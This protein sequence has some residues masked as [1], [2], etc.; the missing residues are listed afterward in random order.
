MPT[1]TLACG[2]RAQQL[3]Q[4]INL[5]NRHSL[6][7]VP[8]S[9][10]L[11]FLTELAHEVLPVD[12]TPSLAEIAAQP[13][14]PHLG[15]PAPAPQHPSEPLRF[16]ILGSDAALSAVLTRLM[17]AD[18]LWAEIAF[19]P[20]S[21]SVA[22]VNWGLSSDPVEAADFAMSA[23]VCPAPTI[24][25]DK[26]LV[27]AGS[28][29]LTAEANAQYTGEIIVDDTTVLFHR[30]SAPEKRPLFG[31]YG[32]RLIPMVDAPGIVAAK[33]IT[34][35]EGAAGRR[36]V[37]LEKLYT[38]WHT[39]GLRWLTRGAHQPAA[40]VEPEHVFQ[41]RAVQTGGEKIIVT[42]DG[43]AA[44]RPVKRATF[45]RHL[46]DLQVVRNPT[47]ESGNFP[48]AGKNT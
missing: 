8:A 38:R 15:H 40:I 9:R 6:T 44:Q 32:A 7:A 25:S 1:H 5:P 24:R 27:V 19:I 34:P 18:H 10:N 33:L 36:R 46:R 22:A 47:A 14:V 21:A 17:R 4:H 20:V 48:Y 28:A 2:N 13:D 43:I 16:I 23:H 26:G 29:T 31:E 3:A 35:L 39:P 11:V 45:Y 12:P 41:G 42:I 30:N 37:P